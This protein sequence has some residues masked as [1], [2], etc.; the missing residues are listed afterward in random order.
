MELVP[1]QWWRTTRVKYWDICI[2]F[3]QRR[4]PDN[5]FYVRTCNKNPKKTKWWYHGECFLHND[6]V[7]FLLLCLTDGVP[8]CVQRSLSPR[9]PVTSTQKHESSFR[10]RFKR[11][12]LIF[13]WSLLS[14]QMIHANVQTVRSVEERSPTDL[15]KALFNHSVS[16]LWPLTGTRDTMR[17]RLLNAFP[18][19]ARPPSA[20]PGS[21]MH[22][23][24]GV[25][26]PRMDRG[27]FLAERY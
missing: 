24:V 6:D 9:H 14:S 3:P 11:C 17:Q 15:R 1:V 10:R 25:D 27:W 2:S 4:P 23:L 5:S 16:E 13:F 20:P 21:W 12:P 8:T 26:E 7:W 22:V 19:P 18:R